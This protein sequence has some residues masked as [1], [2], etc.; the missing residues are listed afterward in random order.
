[1]A[2]LLHMFEG[3][4]VALAQHLEGVGLGRP[5]VLYSNTPFPS[6]GSVI[7]YYWSEFSIP[8]QQVREA[9]LA[10]AK[11][12]MFILPPR[13]RSLY[14]FELTSV[15]AFREYGAKGRPAGA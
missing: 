3:F 2:I 8:Q 7:A 13:G 10:M 4:A 11:E 9:E 12:R 5:Q 15:V 6:E 14:S 1:M